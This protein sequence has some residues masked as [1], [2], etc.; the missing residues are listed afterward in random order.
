MIGSRR[1]LL[2]LLLASSVA[3]LWVSAPAASRGL[4]FYDTADFTARWDGTGVGR[5]RVAPFALLDQA[6]Q[7]MTR[8]ALEGRIHIASFIYTSCAGICPLITRR[9]TGVYAAV[10]DDPEVLLVSYSV[11][12]E[13]DTVEVLGAFAEERGVDS[14]SW[15]LVTGER[16][17]IYRLA[18]DSYFADEDL[19]GERTADDFLHT[20][21][22]MLVDPEL[23]IRGIYNGTLPVDMLS[24]I[25]DVA[26]LKKE[27][28]S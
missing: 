7:S 25:A 9:L 10:R 14:A 28:G 17:A 5:H 12:P 16:G 27:L 1:L 18:R 19:G 13:V 23:R 20:E 8:E 15:K 11:T 26:T 2:C 21:R 22:V 24:L 3:C 4:P 6:G